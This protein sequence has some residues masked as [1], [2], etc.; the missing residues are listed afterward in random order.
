MADESGRLLS[1]FM[2]ICEYETRDIENIIVRE[3][4]YKISLLILIDL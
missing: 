4:K 2:A 1:L 3:I